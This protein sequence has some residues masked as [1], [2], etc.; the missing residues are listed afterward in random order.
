MSF[1]LAPAAA[2]PEVPAEVLP[3]AVVSL[4]DV[5]LEVLSD[6]VDVLSDLLFLLFFFALLFFAGF[7][8]SL[9]DWPLAALRSLVS[10][11]VLA[12]ALAPVPDSDL[13][14]VSA[15]VRLSGVVVL[16]WAA[17]SWLKETASRPEKSAGKNLRI[18][19]LL[20]SLERLK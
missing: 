16:V 14:P 17:A 2:L 12:P 10:V 8:V 4:S 6:L 15:L 9:D 13:M 3:A 11:E 20:R 18:R 5:V 1:V 19:S 7:C